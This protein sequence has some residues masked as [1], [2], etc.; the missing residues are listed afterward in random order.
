MKLKYE[1]YPNLSCLYV[2]GDVDGRNIRVLLVGLDFI[3]KDLEEPLLLH[4]GNAQIPA[5]ELKILTDL[6]K[7]LKD[8]TKHELIWIAKDRGIGDFMSTDLYFSRNSSSKMRSVATRITLDDQVYLLTESNIATQAKISELGGTAEDVEKVLIE[9]EK[10]RGQVAVLN[11]MNSWLM[12]RGAHIAAIPS[13]DPELQ[14]K[15]TEA[16]NKLN[17]LTQGDIGL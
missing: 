3:L 6:K 14:T 17:A 10:L 15:T 5:A 1:R 12:M 16:L 4:F 11:K 2:R 7:K 9:T 8:K 13:E